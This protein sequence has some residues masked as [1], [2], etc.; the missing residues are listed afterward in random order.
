MS[1]NSEGGVISPEVSV[2]ETPEVA[3]PEQPETPNFKGT[4]HRV[5]IDQE[6]REV[7]YDELISDYQTKQASNRRFQQAAEMMKELGATKAEIDAFK[8]DP[9]EALRRA[10]VNPRDWAEKLLLEEIEYEQMSPAEKRAIAAEQK[11]KELEEKLSAREKAEKQQAARQAEAKAVQEIDQEIGAA[12]KELGRRPTPRLVARIAE[13]LIADFEASLEPLRARFGDNVP[14]EAFGS[15]KRMSA[16]DAVKRVQQEYAKDIA[17]YL[18]SLGIEEAR[19]ILPKELLDGL[20][21][22]EVDAVLSQDP[23]RSRK[24]A[25]TESPRVKREKAKRMSS[26]DFFKLKEKKW[27]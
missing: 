26:D 7:D 13:S 11:A 14:D 4:K 2:S 23:M 22:H 5:K 10:G 3:A 25:P 18:G 6:E 24:T 12:L 20:R 9:V 19:K 17:E 8:K 15:V 16:G 21:Q 1:D 27:G